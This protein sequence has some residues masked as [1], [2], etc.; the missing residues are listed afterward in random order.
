MKQGCVLAPT[1]FGIFLATLLKHAFG[2]STEGIY[3]R[4]RSDGNLFKLSRLRAKTRVH[5]KYVRDLLFADD[6]AITTHT[7]EDLQWLLDRFSDACRHFG[8]TIS[9]AKTQV[10][11]QDI[12]EIPSLF[13]HNYKL[14]VVHE[15]VYLGSTITD[16]LSIDSE[17]NKRI[18]KA[19]MTLSRLTNRVWSNNKL[20]DHTKVNV[21]KACVISTLLYGSESWTMHADQ[22]KRL[23]V[24]HMCC[25]RRILGITWQDKVANKVMLEKAGIPSLYTL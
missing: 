23:N 15:F 1:L 16:N 20:S 19:A 4:T 18:G 8:L 5:E 10:M 3:L 2:E 9:L 6:A 14:E 12:Q 21:Y 17:L 7:Q 24:F 11:G 22:E 25:L 13:I